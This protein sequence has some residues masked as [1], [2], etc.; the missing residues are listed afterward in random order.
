M[1]E[2]AQNFSPSSE[3][4]GGKFY[5]T[6]NQPLDPQ[7][8]LFFIAGSA[9]RNGIALQIQDASTRGRFGKSILSPEAPD[10]PF[11]VIA[12]NLPESSNREKIIQWNETFLRKFIETNQLNGTPIFH[13]PQPC[14]IPCDLFAGHVR[15]NIINP[16]P[17]INPTEVSKAAPTNICHTIS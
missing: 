7:K 2:E 12:H 16:N 11:I 13:S 10:L 9:G 6:I 3:V 14:T 15:L 4:I 1:N 5:N 8:G 17:V